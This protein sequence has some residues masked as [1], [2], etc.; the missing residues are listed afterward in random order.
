MPETPHQL[1]DALARIDQAKENYDDL[2][3]ELNKFLHSYVKGMVKGLDRKT[4]NF[5]FQFRHPKES[6]VKGR[7]N[8]LVA[9]IVENLRTALDYLVFQLSVLNNPELNKRTPQFVIADCRSGFEQ[10]AKARLRYLSDEQKILIEK[11]QPYN[12]NELLAVLGEMAGQGKHRYLLTLR[13]ISNFDIRFGE[14][15]KRECY[16]DYFTYPMEKG[17]A[18]FAKPIDEPRFLLIDK[19]DLMRFLNSMIGHVEDVL[20]VSYCFFQG[21]PLKLTILK[22]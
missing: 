19:Y 20:R 2:A 21:R 18:I 14:I 7:P 6:K 4:G 10:Q 1:E 13:D 5:V 11:L 3:Y 16:K 12:G 15:T 9:Q 8:V 17:T 22:E